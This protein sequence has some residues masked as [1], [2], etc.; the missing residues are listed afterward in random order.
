MKKII[1]LGPNPAW[2]KT[3]FF[4]HFIY[5]EI[6]RAVEMQVFPAGKGINF[7][8]AARCH[9]RADAQLI[10]FAGGD[11]GEY[12]NR[13]LA[14]EGMAVWS[15]NTTAPTRSC[16]TCLDR[17]N[18][19][20]TEVIEPSFA[21]TTPE[22]ETMLDYL[23][24][25]LVGADA[26]A[27]CGTLPTGTDPLLYVRAAELV[28]AAGKPLLLDSYRNIDKVLESKAEVWLKI[29]TEE[30]AALTG[31]SGV[32]AGLSALFDLHP[33][34][35]AAITAGPDTAY[36]TAG[37]TLA[38]YELPPLPTIINP[39]GCGDTASGVWMSEIVNGLDP[40]EGF[41]IA[42]GCASANCLSAFPGNFQEKEAQKIAQKIHLTF[43]PFTRMH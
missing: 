35:C 42:L 26:A 17:S 8:R 11:N 14:K 13:E 19:V 15:V 37:K 7:C 34:R 38:C 6:N 31:K 2:Q 32:Q 27:L 9:G 22:V 29:N 5:G 43:T 33:I 24:Q 21:A 39:I 23:R 41:R 4:D 20:M 3:L 36:A 12:I 28:A 30:L 25:G 16:S 1:A 18:Q 10:Q 40:F